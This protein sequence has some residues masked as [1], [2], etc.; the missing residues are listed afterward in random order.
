MFTRKPPALLYRRNL[1]IHE[2]K[3]G[4]GV[5]SFLNHF[6]ILVVGSDVITLVAEVPNPIIGLVLSVLIHVR[7]ENLD[8]VHS[9]IS[10]YHP[11]NHLSWRLRTYVSL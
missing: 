6:A 1:S 5:Q 11:K 8:Q 9:Q 3:L 10:P 7:C 2:S 4:L